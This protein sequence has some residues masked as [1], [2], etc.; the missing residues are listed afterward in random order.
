MRNRHI[1]FF[2]VVSVLFLAGCGSTDSSDEDSTS[3]C[4]P[5]P[6]EFSE[7]DL[8]GTWE[9]GLLDHH[10]TL[11]LREDGKYKQ[12]I[13]IENPPFDYESEWYSWWVEYDQN[14]IPYVHLENMR[15]CVYWSGLGCNQSGGGGQWYDYC[16]DEWISM[17]AGEG[18]LIAIVQENYTQSLYG[19]QLL[20]LQKFE[21]G[22]T[23]YTQ[24]SDP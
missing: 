2:L 19:F 21:E 11:I 7:S 15:M 10:D 8:I 3:P 1:L 4:K 23:A 13:H 14:G 22:V 17:P 6:T 12:I 18:I 9:A 5:P 24:Y 16:Q 20:A